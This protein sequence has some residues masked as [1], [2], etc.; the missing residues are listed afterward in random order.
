MRKMAASWT[1][2]TR[3]M[4]PMCRMAPGFDGVA[5]KAACDLVFEGRAQPSG[6]YRAT[7][8][9]RAGRSARPRPEARKA[10]AAAR[11]SLR[12]PRRNYLPAGSRRASWPGPVIGIIGQFYHVINDRY[13]TH[14][15]GR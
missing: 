13:P 12:G 2:E 14:A 5:F 4:R 8:F 11:L 15:G 10:F 9:M 6:L 1:A 3:A 7:C